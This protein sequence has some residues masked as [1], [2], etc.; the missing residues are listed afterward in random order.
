MA[1]QWTAPS[2]PLDGR[3]PLDRARS[4]AYWRLI[5]LLFF[6]YMIA[7]VDRTNVGIAKLNMSHDLP[8]L[9]SRVF[10]FGAG[11][12]FVGY[13]LLEVPGTLIIERW[14][15]RKWLSR[16]MLTW[17][18][19]A[20]LTAWVTVPWQFYAVRFG[21]GLA[22]AG[23]YPGV[24]VYLTHWFPARDRTRALA[25][26]FIASPIAQMISPKLSNLLLPIG[27]TVVRD[28]VST[29]YP[30]VGG[31][32]G[33]QWVFIAWAIPALILGVI[34]FTSLTDRPR[35]ARWLDD[36]EREALEAELAREK[37]AHAGRA[38]MTVGQAL[39][40]PKV[41]LL[42]GAYLCAVAGNYTIELF[43]PTILQRWYSLGNDALTWLL[44]LPP[45]G[46]LVGQILIGWNSDRTGERRWHT[47]G[48]IVL[49]SLALAGL[50]LIPHPPI[51]LAIV[52][53]LL[54]LTGTKAYLPAFWSL[55]N[56]FL[57]EAAAAG[58]IG[59]INSVGNLGGLVGPWIIGEL[60]TQTG[61]F[62]PGL[63]IMAVSVGLAA[64]VITLSRIGQR[65]TTGV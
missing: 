26:F 60:D 10:G 54:V 53:F 46:S 20:A 63:G 28:G 49:G 16:I 45:L 48:P 57:A 44:I 24:I 31:L 58:S 15:A 42:A 30:L 14:S 11:L 64:T 33:W 1:D 50:A 13:F 9:N 55:P 40:H 43:M 27:T 38:H 65:P 6:S 35:E 18:L 5:P 17:G 41:L 39:R 56:L 3:S 25:S 47:V 29:T 8:W 36:D 37:A 61:S 19:M 32:T 34:V 4:K 62:R 23:F 51:A 2:A 12:F 59:F 52:L 7:Y 22:E 21:L